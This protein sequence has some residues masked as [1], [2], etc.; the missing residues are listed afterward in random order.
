MV[1]VVHNE[2]RARRER[3]LRRNFGER[4]GS[5]GVIGMRHV[6]KDHRHEHRR[7]SHKGTEALRLCSEAVSI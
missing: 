1:V 3:R 2:F 5:G 7:L 6:R 4:E